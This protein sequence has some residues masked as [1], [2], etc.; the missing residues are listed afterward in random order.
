LGIPETSSVAAHSYFTEEDQL[1]AVSWPAGGSELGIDLFK[2][3][4][5]AAS[6]SADSPQLVL[7][8]DA[9]ESTA[10]LNS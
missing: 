4:L 7:F 5:S 3:M 9:L 1:G 6:R 8:S 10:F 2:Q